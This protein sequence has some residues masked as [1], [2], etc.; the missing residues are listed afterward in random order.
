M[1]IRH[2]HIMNHLVALLLV[3]APNRAD[4]G[5]LQLAIKIG[6]RRWGDEAPV[7]SA[8]TAKALAGPYCKDEDFSKP[9]A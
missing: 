9:H 2:G 6:A 8:G 5:L 3:S 7:L 4:R 1:G